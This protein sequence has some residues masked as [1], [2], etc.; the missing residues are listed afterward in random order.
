VQVQET[1]RAFYAGG[2][3][4]LAV[5]MGMLTDDAEPTEED[6][7]NMDRIKAEFDEYA[8]DLAEGRA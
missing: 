6:I 7:R 1:R 8:R 2:V 5:V 3:S 4:L